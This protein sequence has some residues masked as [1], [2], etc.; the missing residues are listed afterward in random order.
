MAAIGIPILLLSEYWVF[1]IVV[2]IMS[3]IAV[4]E[5][6]GVTGFRKNIFVCLPAYA[7]AIAL[8]P[9][10]YKIPSFEAAFDLLVNMAA[11][12][13]LFML[14]LIGYS[15]VKRGAV[16]LND[17]ALFYVYYVYITFAF[18][19]VT[20]LRYIPNGAYSY[21]MIFIA[22]WI[23][24]ISAYFVG[25]AIGKHKL[26]PAVSPKKTWEGAIGGVFFTTVAFL[27]YGLVLTFIEGAP[28]PNFLVLALLGAV[29]SIISQF[30]DLSASLLKREKGIKDFGKIFP[31]HG[32]VMDRFDSV[33]AVSIMLLVCF[34]ALSVL[35]L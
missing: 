28:A 5:L 13:I 18:T 32:G 21:M 2:S 3:A 17:I 19:S 33:L 30:G 29:L 7:I 31:G 35:G 10:C 25:F 6:L 8:P 26:I 12:A 9:F 34:T 14:Y 1:P 22:A 24:D 27:I 20:L 4:W 11:A 15:V 16:K 23:C